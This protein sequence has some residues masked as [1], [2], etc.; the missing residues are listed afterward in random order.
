MAKICYL[1]EGDRPLVAIQGELNIYQ[2][3]HLKDEL[4]AVLSN[5]SALDLDLADVEDC[6]SSGVQ[7]L[8]LLKREARRQDKHLSL[9][10]HSSCVTEV[11]EL[12]NLVSELGDPLVLPLSNPR[13]RP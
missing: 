5:Q 6:D 8:L 7:L 12:L 1:T 13:V 11:I 3:A 10:N 9:V 2:A 4:L